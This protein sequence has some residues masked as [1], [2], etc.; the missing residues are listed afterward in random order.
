MR[1]VYQGDQFT[2]ETSLPGRPVYLLVH[3][4]I[5]VEA[6][7]GCS[8]KFAGVDSLVVESKQ[9]PDSWK[10]G[11]EVTLCVSTRPGER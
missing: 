1:P 7:S 5:D 4:E 6:D 10:G 3:T 2:R 9:I 11:G 8:N